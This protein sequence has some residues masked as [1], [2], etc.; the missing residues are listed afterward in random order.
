MVEL[1]MQDYEHNKMIYQE[2]SQML[3]KILGENAEISHVGSTALPDMLGKNIIDILVGANADLFASYAEIIAKNG[4]FE[5]RHSTEIYKFFAS[6]KEETLAG[7][8][9][10]HLVVKN[11]ERYNE[12]LILKN[13]LLN[14]ASARENYKA[15]KTEILTK[16]N[17]RD[18]YRKLK[19]EYVSALIKQA[20]DD[21]A[22]TK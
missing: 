19:S 10:I 15:Y 12:F 20:K 3:K 9:H 18:M 2:T 22:L 17:D 7:D 14:N 1:L 8:I 6:R 5:G 13:Y 11:T 16:T 4:Y 21:L